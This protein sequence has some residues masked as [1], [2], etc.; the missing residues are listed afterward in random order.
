LLYVVEHR[1]DQSAEL[2]KYF[3]SVQLASELRIGRKNRESEIYEI[4]AVQ[5]PK[6]PITGRMP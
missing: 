3:S 2:R 4:Y 6:A 1:R 5:T